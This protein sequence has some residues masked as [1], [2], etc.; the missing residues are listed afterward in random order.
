MKRRL[1]VPLAAGACVFAVAT[2][3]AAVPPERVENVTFDPAVVERDD[4]LSDAC[5]FD[6]TSSAK[7]HFRLTVHLDRNGE[8]VRAVGHPSFTNTLT[9]PGGTVTTADRGMDR[10]TVDPDG[11]LTVFGT[12]IHLKIHGGAHAIGL[13]VLVIDPETDELL[14]AEYHGRFDVLEPEIVGELC[15][16]LGP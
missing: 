1:F 4:F 16:A 8:F 13:W 10:I 12:G 6:V 7:G 14:S 5:G 2:P 3:A 9:G 11:T 15:T